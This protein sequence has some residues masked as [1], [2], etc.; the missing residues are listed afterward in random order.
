MRQ[1]TTINDFVQYVEIYKHF[2]NLW[3]LSILND[4]VKAFRKCMSTLFTFCF[5]TVLRILLIYFYFHLT[6]FIKNHCTYLNRS[7]VF[8]IA[9]IN[10]KSC[11][12][13]ERKKEFTVTRTLFDSFLKGD[14]PTKCS[15]EWLW[16][17]RKWNEKI[18]PPP[19][20]LFRNR[21]NGD[22]QFTVIVLF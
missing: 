1:N 9:L 20:N 13:G 10:A 6:V 18:C 12:Q 15:G 3:R 17:G 11:W 16:G 21:I 14:S 7:H 8:V 5:P 2:H 19:K 4:E 22:F